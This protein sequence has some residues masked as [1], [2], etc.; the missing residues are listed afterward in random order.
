MAFQRYYN[1]MIDEFITEPIH[2]QIFDSVMNGSPQDVKSFEEMLDKNAKSHPNCIHTTVYRISRKSIAKKKQTY[3]KSAPME[4]IQ[5]EPQQ[6]GPD[7]FGELIQSVS[8]F[9]RD[10]IGTFLTDLTLRATAASYVAK[11]WA[12]LFNGG[13]VDNEAIARRL[14][15]K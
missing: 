6:Y 1:E 12:N 10:S 14:Y 4:A 5:S 3:L 15:G 13:A 8:P 2:E 9:G 11:K 7:G